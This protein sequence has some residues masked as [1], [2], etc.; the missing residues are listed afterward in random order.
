MCSIAKNHSSC[1]NLLTTTNNNSPTAFFAKRM[2]RQGHHHNQHFNLIRK[3]EKLSNPSQER[4]STQY[5]QLQ[6]I[7]SSRTLES[8][9]HVSVERE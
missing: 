8:E 9:G 4:C 7:A 3:S 2:S 5:L 6:H 1:V